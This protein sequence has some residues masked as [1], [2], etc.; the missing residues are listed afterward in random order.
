LLQR[1]QHGD[2]K[3]LK[4]GQV[5]T[6]IPEIMEACSWYSGYG[7]DKPT[8]DQINQILQ[9]LRQPGEGAYGEHR[10]ATKEP[11]L[12]DNI[13]NNEKNEINNSIWSLFPNAKIGIVICH[14]ID[15]S[16]RNRI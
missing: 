3:Q 5:R 14:D 11:R 2:F 4:R 6:S 1:A 8:K 16:I 7:K 12:P 15:N 13:N 9:W 10:E